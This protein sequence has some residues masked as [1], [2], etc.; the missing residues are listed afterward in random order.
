MRIPGRFLAGG[1]VLALLAATP[2]A[3]RA[4]DAVTAS[5][6]GV[7]A[8]AVAVHDLAAAGDL[9]R[10]AAP[11]AV[12]PGARPGVRPGLTFPLR[13][14]IA[15]R[16]VSS[17]ENSSLNWRAQYG[18]IED[19][20]DGRGY[21]GGIVGFCSGTSDMRQ[22]VAAYTRRRPANPLARYLPAL[23]RVDGTASHAGLDPTFVRDWRRAAA[24][25]VFQR[26]QDAERD[27][28]YFTPAVARAQADGLRALG[29]FAYYDAAVMHGYSGL[30][31]IRAAALRRA[32][33]PAGGG[34]ETAYLHAFLDA[35]V[36]EMRTEAAHSD[37]SRVDTAQRIFLRA[38]NLDLRR[39]MV[40][41]VYGD[42]YQLG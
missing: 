13:K 20:R 35:R 1:V 7:P 28:L 25:P 6:G 30:L 14:E 5:F 37:T 10:A 24:D 42:R 2:L 39:P 38:G 11:A 3:V 18:Y 40:W 36:R 41:W 22:L 8:I 21:T 27:R 31:R 29:Q 23:R 12:P 19:I 32:K 9:G 16:L 33:A 26:T 4:A 34:G 17:A 15:M